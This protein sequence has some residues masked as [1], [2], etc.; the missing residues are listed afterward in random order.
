MKDYQD[1]NLWN[2]IDKYQNQL[3][4]IANWELYRRI[5]MPTLDII[6]IRTKIKFYFNKSKKPINM[7]IASSGMSI[8]SK[9]FEE[10]NIRFASIYLS[11]EDSATVE[12]IEPTKR[13]TRELFEIYSDHF[14]EH[15]IHKITL[16]RG[17][18]Q[19]EIIWNNMNQ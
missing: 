19:E 17:E 4:G 14:R 16:K 7:N 2:F 13:I 8:I 5:I 3:S 15:K 1:R 10:Y 18:D 11:G 6:E 12:V 9:D